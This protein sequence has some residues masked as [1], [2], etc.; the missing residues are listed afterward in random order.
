MDVSSGDSV[1]SLVSSV[2]KDF[3]APPCIA[4]NAAGITRDNFLL[5]MDEKS[6]DEVMNVNLKVRRGFCCMNCPCVAI[7][8][9]FVV[10]WLVA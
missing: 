3:S 7:G 9:V 10:C 1:R 5:K 2:Q 8:L 6:F 4:V